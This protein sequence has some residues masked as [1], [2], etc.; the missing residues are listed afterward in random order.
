[1]LSLAD[2]VRLGGLGSILLVTSPLHCYRA[3]HAGLEVVFRARSFI[4]DD[5]A[6]DNS[7]RAGPCSRSAARNQSVFCDR[8]LLAATS[9]EDENGLKFYRTTAWQNVFGSS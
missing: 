4:L 1:M 7:G 5:D 9:E 6:V 3:V 2:L 8:R